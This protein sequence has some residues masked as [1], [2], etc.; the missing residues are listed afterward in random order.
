MAKKYDSAQEIITHHIHTV[1]NELVLIGMKTI[2]DRCGCS[3]P[4]LYRWI[5]EKGF[6]AWREDGRWR[7]PLALVTAWMEKRCIAHVG[8]RKK[9]GRS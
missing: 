2:A 3:I 4:T 5:K 9:G 8:A 6:P 1:R 7:A